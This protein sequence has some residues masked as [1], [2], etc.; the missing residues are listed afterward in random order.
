MPF[1][2]AWSTEGMASAEA[3]AVSA[4][5]AAAQTRRSICCHCSARCGVLVDLDAR[6]EPIAIRGDP[7]HPISRGFLCPRGRAAIEYF[8]HPARLNYPLRR[9]GARGE[10]RWQRVSWE[11]ALDDIAARLLAIRAESGAEA[12][13]YLCG[14]FHGADGNF[15][16]RLMHHFGSPNSGGI[17]PICAGPR[18]M[19]DALTFGYGPSAPEIVPGTTRAV[20]LWAYHPSASNPPAWS[21]I[22]AAQR[23]GARL[24]AIDPRPTTEARHA[25][26][27]LR[28]RP[29]SDAALA[30]GLLHVLLAEGLWDRAFVERW[31]HSFDALRAR[32]T[33]YPPER[34]AALTGVAPEQ[35]RQAAR[36]YATLAPAALASGAPNG[37]GRNALNFE[38]ALCCLIALTG[39]LDRPGGN[40]LAG[41]Q[42]AVGNKTTGEDYAALPPAQRAKR[43]GAERYRLLHE[44]FERLS[45]AARRVWYGI[46]YPYSVQFWAAAHPPTLF[47]AIR[48]GQ[49]YPVRA[50]WVQH[51]NLL[52]CYSNSQEEYAAL[53]SPNLELF[54]V[55]DLWLT[56]T[57]ML[58]DYVLPAASWLEK[59]FLWSTGRGDPV[60]TGE[61]VTAPR[62]ERR[63]DYELCRDL[64]RRLGQQW[65]ERV[66]AVWDQWLAGAETTFDALVRARQWWLPA[67]G[68]R[69]RHEQP[70]PRTGAPL[71]FGTPTGKVELASTVLAELGYD[72]LPGHDPTLD[73]ALD[74]ARYP[75]WLMVGGT[76]IDALHQDH[77]QI[78]SLRRR[79]PDPQVELDP[80][81]AAAHGI[82]EGDWVRIETPR[83]AIYQRA[84][85][86]PDLGTDVVNAERWWYPER[87]GRAPALYGFWESNVSAYTEDDPALCDPAYGAWP[88]RVAVCR[89]ARATA[90]PG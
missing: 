71:G 6:G 42:P 33:E 82:A 2:E 38:R 8:Q 34:V 49:P 16:Y 54:V 43:L 28:P 66:E 59:P 79:H 88:F 39:N 12:V 31:T 1:G 73:A 44:G 14:T 58:A 75:L 72:P 20:L 68:E 80:R 90:P 52:G 76:R 77:R 23:A 4:G 40:R 64:G 86:V 69:S 29:G 89:I 18:L 61:Q 35:L 47:R 30:L 62:H 32:A 27:W 22:L 63:S 37:L 83:G 50:L 56:P 48:T 51:N 7:G 9:V 13:A 57:A 67:P 24:I 5:A 87:E 53:V 45:A 10:G 78:A 21:R 19:A 15:G 11:E 55:H 65:P 74:R 36:W 70:D 81:L 84:R 26:L 3:S 85:L 41:P 25:D 17:G 46:P 60:L